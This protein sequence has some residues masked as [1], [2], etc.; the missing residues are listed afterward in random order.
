MC[1]RR[2]PSPALAGT[3]NRARRPR[4][5]LEN[6][7][8]KRWTISAKASTALDPPS[9]R[10]PSVCR[11]PDAPASS[12]PH[13]RRARPAPGLAHR[14]RAISS[15]ARPAAPRR[16]LPLAHERH[17]A[18]SSGKAHRRPRITPSSSRQRTPR[19]NDPL[20]RG[21]ARPS[22]PHG[23]GERR[24]ARHPRAC[25]GYIE[26]SSFTNAGGS[27]P[28]PFSAFHPA[29]R[30][31]FAAEIGTPTSA[32]LRGWSAI[33]AGEPHADCGAHRIR[34]DTRCLSFHAQ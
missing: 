15:E 18:R 8:A 2:R 9:R 6:S 32:Q 29:V 34:Q 30:D 4:R 11:R 14:P 26:R 28:V 7:F 12:F 10:L 1:L 20:P 24:T 25:T 19:A 13:R 23:H 22:A 17:S 21:P 3:H 33:A 27:D 16:V 5:K 31:W